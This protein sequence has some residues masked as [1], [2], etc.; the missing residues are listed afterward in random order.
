MIET[1][2]C[3]CLVSAVVVGDGR[4]AERHARFSRCLPAVPTVDNPINELD[5]RGTSFLRIVQTGKL[6]EMIE[7]CECWRVA[8]CA[9]VDVLKTSRL[10]GS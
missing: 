1:C 10:A 8:G 7:T 3:W 6:V 5:L 4:L 9:R 2:R